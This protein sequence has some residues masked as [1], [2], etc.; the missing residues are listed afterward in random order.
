MGK[1][2]KL[3]LPAELTSI[4]KFKHFI[5]DACSAEKLGE[6]STYDMKLAVEEACLNIIEHGYAGMNP[7]SILVSFQGGRRQIVVRIT[8]FGHPFEP[9]EPPPPDHE[10]VA[11]GEAVGFGLYF[12]Y[13][14]VDTITYET[15]ETCNTLTFIKKAEK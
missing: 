7:G 11:A 1:K 15:N 8:D 10:A 4:S 13:R 3:A 14:S 9:S 2:R 5:E 6:D 12:M